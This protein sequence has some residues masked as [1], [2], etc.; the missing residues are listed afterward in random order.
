MPIE[1]VHH[2]GD[3]PLIVK[4]PTRSRG[5]LGELDSLTL[6]VITRAGFVDADLATLGFVPY[7]KVP[8]YEAMFTEPFEDEDESEAVAKASLRCV[9]LLTA[10]EKRRRRISVNTKEISLGPSEGVIYTLPEG[11]QARWSVKDAI[12]VVKDTY[13]TTVRPNTQIIGSRYEPPNAPDVPAYL[14]W[15]GM[16]LR[17]NFPSQWVLDD[18]QIEC[19]AG[20][21]NSTDPGAALWMVEDTTGY[22][23]L[24]NPDT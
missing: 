18:R 13:F 2:H 23:Q 20:D 5:K 10:G 22:Y 15:F 1:S 12:L 16:P 17:Y 14:A 8:G 11:S 19:V 3:L 21:E 7:Q 24:A 4:G 9:G 6:E